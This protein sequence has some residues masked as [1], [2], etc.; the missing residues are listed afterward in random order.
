MSIKDKYGSTV[1][2]G[3]VIIIASQ[4][5]SIF[6]GVFIGL[7]PKNRPFYLSIYKDFVR[8]NG[9]VTDYSLRNDYWS[10]N[11]KRGFARG[12]IVLF[13]KKNDKTWFSQKDV[14]YLPNEKY[15]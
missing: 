13:E 14:I 11:N 15:K 1:E 6:L 10:I 8:V 5:Y 4:S 12:E 2:I 7:S 3:D 9:V